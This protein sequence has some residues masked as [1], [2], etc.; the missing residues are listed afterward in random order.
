M[1]LIADIIAA[2]ETEAPLELQ[3]DWDNSGLQVG[4]RDKECSGVMIAL[5]P[6]EKVVEE[7]VARG[8]NL[9]VTHHP[10]IFHAPCRIVGE[11]GQQRTIELAIRSG[12]AVY[13]AHTSLDKAPRGL[14]RIAAEMLGLK[15]IQPLQHDSRMAGAGLGAVG[16]LPEPLTAEQFVELVKA[17]FG[18]PVVRCSAAFDR[19]SCDEKISRVALC[20]GSGSSL[21][22]DAEAAGAQVFLTSDTRYHD[23]LDRGSERL[24][25]ADIG[26]H[27]SEFMSREIFYHLISE[28]FSNF[29]V[30]MSES[31]VANPIV[32]A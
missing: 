8:C 26:H 14:N 27:E 20:T 11:D 15:D 29:A 19:Y 31:D 17:R 24:M 2:I 1:P 3:E 18:S 7:A 23:F 25:I 30:R 12:V 21:L 13:S 9:V 6:T 32:Y 4:R 10:L 22:G 16:N 28:K 5:D